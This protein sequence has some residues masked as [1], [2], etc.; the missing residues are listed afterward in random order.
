MGS[1][2]VDEVSEDELD[3][4]AGTEELG[5]LPAGSWDRVVR[6]WGLDAELLKAAELGGRDA[7]VRL[8]AK[9]K[10]FLVDSRGMPIWPARAGP[11]PG[12]LVQGELG[13]AL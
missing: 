3:D 11:R 8:L 1:V 2:G 6:I 13:L 9:H 12:K 10:A 5:S 7:V 4:D